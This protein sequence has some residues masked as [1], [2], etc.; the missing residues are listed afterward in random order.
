MIPQAVGVGVLHSQKPNS[1]IG[2]FDV[3][4]NGLGATV[5]NKL[6]LVEEVLPNVPRIDFSHLPFDTSQPPTKQNMHRWSEDFTNVVWDKIGAGSGTPPSIVPNNALAP[7]GT[8]TA[9]TITFNLNG[10]TT[11]SDRSIL[12]QAGINQVQSKTF[13]IYLR[14]PSGTARVL[15]HDGGDSSEFEVTETWTRYD[16][17]IGVA[18]VFAG[19]SM[20]GTQSSVDT[21]VLEVWGSQ[22]ETG[23]LS[24]YIPTTDERTIRFRPLVEGNGRLLTETSSTNEIQRS[25][26][27][28]NSYWSKNDCIAIDNVILGP[29]GK[30]S[31]SVI[32]ATG[33]NAH[34]VRSE[35]G[36]SSIGQ[37]KS[38]YAKLLSGGGEVRLLSTGSD[39]FSFT[40]TDEWQRFEV[41]V[42]TTAVTE[43]FFYGVDF[44]GG[45]TTS[46]A[47]WGGQLEDGE[48]AGTYISSNTGTTTT[49][50]TDSI[51]GAGDS[52]VFKSKDFT[53]FVKLKTL[54]ATASAN[55]VISI[56]DGT[57]SNRVL[58]S[59]IQNGSLT[60]LLK[61]DGVT[62]ATHTR[63]HDF[64]NLTSV[65]IKLSDNVFS[66]YLD[67]AK[68]FETS[69][70]NSP[71]NKFNELRLDNAVGSEQ[72]EGF[73]EQIR[74]I[75]RGL[76]ESEISKLAA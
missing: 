15:R 33:S 38:I 53:F 10:G 45:N 12:R 6:G 13:S 73:I 72:F 32:T 49:R 42:E 22:F 2:D 40:L 68:V 36:L 69:I 41:P 28:E 52:N 31:A 50:P 59:P 63:V 8:M 75:D 11:L 60:V 58:L 35:A 27:F 51:T 25:E 55:R 23:E 54:T 18:N 37:V 61:V 7:N 62:E 3:S 64:T 21:S 47:I 24:D 20:R 48:N 70:N 14:S 5:T 29:D 76:T 66:V 44:R 39:D 4:R 67:E 71:E 56:S 30:L 74:Y 17:P 19:I 26:S 34:I 46:V 57:T 9:D 1:H 16:F 65:I 43:Q